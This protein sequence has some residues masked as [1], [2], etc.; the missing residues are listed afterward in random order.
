MANLFEAAATNSALMTEVV[1]AIASAASE[2]GVTFAGDPMRFVNLVFSHD[3]F[4]EALLGRL[5]A[6]A[7][8][9]GLA[10]AAEKASA[11]ETSAKVNALQQ[12][13]KDNPTQI[14]ISQPIAMIFI[15]AA[16]MFAPSSFRSVG[17][18]LFGGDTVSAVEGIVPFQ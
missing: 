5:T 15:A 2:V 4:R 6:L 11:E 8:S 18:T 13:Q 14:P 9:R 17:G 7:A 1:D 10:L 16:L 3:V 12:L